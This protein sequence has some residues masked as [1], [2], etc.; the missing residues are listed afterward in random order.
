VADGDAVASS[1]TED[2]RTAHRR[3][4]AALQ[5]LHERERQLSTLMSNLP[6]MAYRY[7][8]DQPWRMQFVSEG[9]LALTGYAAADLVEDRTVSFA[10]LI[11]PEDREPVR[12]EVE[13]ALERRQ[14]FRLSYRL[15][16]AAGQERWVWEQ[17]QGVFDAHDRLL[18]L[19]GFIADVTDRRRAERIT[20][21]LAQLG[22]ELS[23][24]TEVVQAAR[25]VSRAAQELIGCD[26]GFLELRSEDLDRL[27][28][29]LH[30]DTVNG[31]LTEVPAIHKTSQST[32]SELRLRSQ[33]AF[34]VLRA[35]DEPPGEETI[36]FGDPT[37]RSASLLYVP[38][39]FQ[40]KYLGRLSIQSYRVGAYAPADLDLLQALADHCAGALERIRAETRLRKLARAVEQS[41]VSIIV[42][43]R[44]GNIEFVN[45][46]FTEVSGYTAGEV[47]GRNPRLLKSGETPAETYRQLWASITAG[48]EWRGGLRNRRKDGTF[49]WE[50]VSISPVRDGAGEV[51]HFIAVKEDV[52]EKKL[53]ET[54]FL[55]AQRIEGIGSLA[56]GI[57]HDLNNILAPILMCA[58]LLQAEDSRERRR[59]I[60]QT[61]EASA[62]RAAGIIRQ[63]LSF[64][65]GKEGQRGPVQVRH[66]IR[67]MAKIARETFPR[68]IQVQ[69]ACAGD[70]WLVTADP[71]QIHQVLLNLCVNARDAMPNGGRLILRASNVI[72]DE[73]FTN[74]HR[75][76]SAGPHLRL[77]VQ[78]TG[79]GIPESLQ[80]HIFELFFTTKGE[81][82]GTG[83]GLTTVK[84][85]VMDHK[86]FIDFTTVPGKGT[87]FTVHLPAAPE[88]TLQAGAEPAGA[89]IP[90]GRGELVL[91]V[92]DEPAVCLT[93]CRAL[94]RYGYVALPAHDGT[95]ALAQFNSRRR[96]VRVVVTDYMMPLMDGVALSRALRALSPSTPIV[97]SSGGLFGK[98]G[99][100]ALHA[101]ADLG[102]SHVLH[103]PHTAEVLLRHLEDVLHSQAKAAPEPDQ[104][105]PGP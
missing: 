62:N 77:E 17:G 44:S 103:K 36:P 79:T 35:P 69:D 3:T 85:I 19:E 51:T 38:L 14:P 32:P 61:I 33:G 18:A 98:A 68:N 41:P 49:F 100:E 7:R 24:T 89:A 66:L 92:D 11:H 48:R 25:I 20:A 27:E 1:L 71:T 15:R 28:D 6:G 43:D 29:V 10:D 86:G 46:K 34:M 60:I 94:E 37:R 64:A 2:A 99:T 45:P 93:T 101:F 59:E 96:E 31:R 8:N 9:A 54:K 91:V 47:L 52:T 40:E 81:R 30:W 58:P 104:A 70:L 83:L 73:Q 74:Q 57:A 50:N 90:R 65:R 72:L 21:E 102:I 56:S 13:A 82:E 22:R 87:T 97:V 16:T 76:A 105:A 4:E 39:R 95:E 23:S 80:G 55:R 5:A 88:V 67:E 12:A 75:E 26:C 53:M 63:L 84:G 42:T 78:D